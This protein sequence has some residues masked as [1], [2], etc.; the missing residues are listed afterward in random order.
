MRAGTDGWMDKRRALGLGVLVCRVGGMIGRS[1]AGMG[2]VG[3]WDGA[4]ERAGARRRW[5]GFGTGRRSPG[6]SVFC[7]VNGQCDVTPLVGYEAP[8]M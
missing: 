4:E 2:A 3:V 5:S 6:C 7:C 8:T 1:C